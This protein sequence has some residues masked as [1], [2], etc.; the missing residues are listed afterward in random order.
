M[1]RLPGEPRDA[2]HAAVPTRV[3]L[4]EVLRPT[5]GPLPD[6]QG[7]GH[8]VHPDRRGRGGDAAAD[9]AE[10]ARRDQG[11]AES[12]LAA[13]ANAAGG[14]GRDGLRVRFE[15]P[16]VFFSFGKPKWK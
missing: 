10:R 15:S 16:V 7:P 2:G 12:V 6:V 1:R 4:Q 14:L 8:L 13:L 11:A 5:D 9:A 3:H